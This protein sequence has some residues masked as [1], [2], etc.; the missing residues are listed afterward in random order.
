MVY[1][2]TY[3]TVSIASRIDNLQTFFLQLVKI[4]L[5]AQV[6]LWPLL[7]E[8]CTLSCCHFHVESVSLVSIS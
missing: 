2:G 7:F 5:I 6:K 3:A 4:L 1:V 8:N